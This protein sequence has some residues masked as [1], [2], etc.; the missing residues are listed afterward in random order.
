[1]LQKRFQSLLKEKRE[2]QWGCRIVRS[3]RIFLRFF[4]LSLCRV[5]AFGVHFGTRASYLFNVFIF[6]FYLFCCSFFYTSWWVILFHC[7]FY[8]MHFICLFLPT[9]ML[10]YPFLDHFLILHLFSSPLLFFWGGIN[11]L[12]SIFYLIY[13]YLGN[14]LISFN[15]L[16]LLVISLISPVSVH[17]Y[18]PFTRHAA[19]FFPSSSF[20]KLSFFRPF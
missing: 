7:Y 3:F 8:F 1:M 9:K 10:C 2:T 18:L 11:F 20:V 5:A 17:I 13:L 6:T 14:T 15:F 16:A 4:F 19:L 12:F